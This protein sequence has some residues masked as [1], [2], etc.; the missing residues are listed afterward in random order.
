MDPLEV[1]EKYHG[2]TQIE[3]QFRIMKGDLETRPLYI[4]TPEHVGGCCFINDY[5]SIL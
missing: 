4:R 5:S 1:I 2:L 3:D